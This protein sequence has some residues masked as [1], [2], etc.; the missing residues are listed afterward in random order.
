M[1]VEGGSNNDDDGKTI[2]PLPLWP[3]ILERAYE[4]SSDI[5]HLSSDDR[6]KK[7]NATGIY[8]LLREVLEVLCQRSVDGQ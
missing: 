7:K 2:I 8:Y 4:R 6:K 1:K 5:S 3:I